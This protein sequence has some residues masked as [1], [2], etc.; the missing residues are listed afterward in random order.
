MELRLPAMF[1]MSAVRPCRWKRVPSP[2]GSMMSM[3]GVGRST[4]PPTT[5]ACSPWL[6]TRR[7]SNVCHSGD[8]EVR[9]LATWPASVQP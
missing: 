4:W 1:T 8:C 7:P 3:S 6:E 9:R 2:S 5:I